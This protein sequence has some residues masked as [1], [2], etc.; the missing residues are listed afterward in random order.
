M[1]NEFDF[2]STESN[3]LEIDKNNSKIAHVAKQIVHFIG[4]SGIGWLIDFSLLNILHIV[5]T[6]IFVCNLLSSFIAVSFVFILSARK[7]FVQNPNGIN[8]RI[9]F[10]LYV[11]YQILLITLM[12]FLLKRISVATAQFFSDSLIKNFSAVIS[13]I[14][15]TPITMILNFIV[16]KLLIERI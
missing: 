13:K 8:I 3:I 2:Y 7:N 9:K 15:I 11:I 10:V 14:V 4:I 6:D 5:I 1:A 16:M 12:S